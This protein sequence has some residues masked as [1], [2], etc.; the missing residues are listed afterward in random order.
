MPKS[1]E[2]SLR[3]KVGGGNLIQHS[4]PVVELRVPFVQTHM[5]QIRL[6]NFHRPPMKR[7]SHGSLSHPG[8]HAVQPLL[9]HIKKKSKQREAERMASGGG[10]VFFMR[11]PE[12]LTGKDGD[13][14]LIEFCEEHPP[15]MNQVTNEKTGLEIWI[16]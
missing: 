11:T 16:C 8:P 15:L 10:D 12:D 3:L 1:S 4:T 7:Y 5:G 14:I 13:L 2:T 6:R 9:K